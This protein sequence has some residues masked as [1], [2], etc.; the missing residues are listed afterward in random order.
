MLSIFAF[1][2]GGLVTSRPA[3]VI[4]GLAFALLLLFYKYAAF[5]WAGISPGTRWADL[6]LLD[7]DGRP[8]GRRDR[9][10][11]LAAGCLSLLPA[12][13][14]LLWALVDEEHLTWHDHMSKTFVT[15]AARRS[16]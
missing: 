8:P 9:L 13:A 4:Y 12:G 6:D 7:F 1:Q 5:R 3:L 15:P 10:N 16:S 14:G 2:T 11:R